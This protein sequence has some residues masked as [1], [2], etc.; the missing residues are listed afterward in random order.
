MQNEASHPQIIANRHTDT[1]PDLELPLSRHHFG[2]GTAN[3]D[4]SKETSTIM[5]VNHITSNHFVGTDTTIV[6]TGMRS[7][8][9]SCVERKSTTHPCGAGKPFLGQP[10]GRPSMSNNVYS[11]SMP[12]HGSSAATLVA[13][14][15]HAFRLLVASGVPSYLYVSQLRECGESSMIA[16]SEG[17][18]TN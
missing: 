12:N 17:K 18:A 13:T 14:S 16:G 6:R 10:S 3:L 4:A 2:I 5:S 8:S 1:R 15:L 11:C 9:Y 7:V